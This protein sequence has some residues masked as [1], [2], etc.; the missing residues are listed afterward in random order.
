MPST[1]SPHPLA[2]S[3][4][5][6]GE[7]GY[8]VVENI[9]AYLEALYGAGL[10]ETLAAGNPGEAVIRNLAEAYSII[11]EMIFWQEDQDYDQ[12][13]KAF[14]LFVEY[15]TEMQLSLGDLHHITEIVTSFFDWEADSE[16]PAHLDELKPSIQSLTNLFNRGEYKSAIYSALAEHSYKDVD[17]LIGMA[18]WFYGEDEFELFFSCAQHYP[19]RALS[20]AYWLIDLNDE[21]RQRFIA[22][23]RRFMPSERLGK[24]LSQTQV[25]T[26]IEK[27]ILDRVIFHQ[28]HLLKNQKDHRDFA[29]WGMCSED[30]LIALHGAYLLEELPVAIWPQGSKTIIESLLVWTEPHWN[31]VKRKDGKSQ[32]VKSQDWLREL[33][34]RV[35]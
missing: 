25:Y 21:Q 13:L 31:S 17:D 23:A 14:P 34:E 9:E 16:G 20:N 1:Q 3:L 8:P 6:V 24:T 32:Y 26:E 11:S 10:Y 7:I 22:W 15:V 19:L 12:A 27:R 4:Y 5:S 33:L 35:T 30:R 29:I 2:V 28:E 18:H